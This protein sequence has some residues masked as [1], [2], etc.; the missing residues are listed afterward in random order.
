MEASIKHFTMMSHRLVQFIYEMVQNVD[1]I[2][3]HAL[4]PSLTFALCGYDLR[5]QKQLS[6]LNCFCLAA[7]MGLRGAIL[8]RYGQS[9]P[10]AVRRNQSISTSLEV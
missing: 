7:K 6:H 10:V 1:D 5:D 2:P 9:H 3:Q 8:R 4:A